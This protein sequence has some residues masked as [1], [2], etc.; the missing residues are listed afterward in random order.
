MMHGLQQDLDAQKSPQQIAVTQRLQIGKVESRAK[1]P[2]RA[3]DNG[4]LDIFCTG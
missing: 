4:Q 3:A 1:M 2:A